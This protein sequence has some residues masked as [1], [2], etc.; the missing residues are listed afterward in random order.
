MKKK[1]AILSLLLIVLML[2]SPLSS[3][4]QS[5]TRNKKQ[6]TTTTKKPST[7]SPTTKEHKQ[8]SSSNGSGKS[9]KTS[10]ASKQTTS[11]SKGMT[12]AQKKRIIQQ[13]I[14]DMVFVEGGTFSMGLEADGTHITS[15]KQV[16]LS[17][18]YICK[19]EVTQELWQAVMDNNPSIF[20]GHPKNPVECVSWDDCQIFISKLNRITGKNFRLP[21][22]AEWEY[23][24]RG[25]KLSKGYK[26]SGSDDL[27]IVGWYDSNSSDKTHPVG[28]KLPNEL[29][30]YDMSGNVFEW[31]S[32]W[33]YLIKNDPSTSR[34]SE[35]RGGSWFSNYY[36]CRI[37]HPDSGLSDTPLNRVGLRLAL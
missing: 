13:A 35:Y 15:V 29:G 16:T 24:A 18:F 26:Y 11:R 7:N 32:D 5:I 4:G 37:S 9:N 2:L 36:W 6:P 23:A 34:F 14:D 33:E 10:K 12:Q 27:S 19:Y 8:S 20:Y 17:S 31:C 3:E 28:T 30:L 22:V 1:T 25:G 21:S